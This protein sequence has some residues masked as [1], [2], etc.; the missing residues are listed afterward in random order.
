MQGR[1]TVD[2]GWGAVPELAC[3]ASDRDRGVR[4]ASFHSK[5]QKQM[6]AAAVQQPAS[7]SDSRS[8]R[9]W[10]RKGKRRGVTP[11]GIRHGSQQRSHCRRRLVEQL[12]GALSE[13]RVCPSTIQP[14]HGGLHATPARPESHHLSPCRATFV[15]SGLPLRKGKALASAGLLAC[16]AGVL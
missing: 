9:G 8:R 7:C 10:L 5:T 4:S 1:Y 3:P 15:M 2:T 12:S 11:R 16:W 13:G 14:Q 6:A